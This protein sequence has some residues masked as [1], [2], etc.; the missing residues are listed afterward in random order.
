MGA[1]LRSSTVSGHRARQGRPPGHRRHRCAA[2]RAI[3]APR[4]AAVPMAPPGT[5]VAM[6]KTTPFTIG[7]DAK[8]TDGACGKVTCVVVDPV[9]R[10][11]T[12]LVVEKH[13]YD[14]RV[15]DS[16]RDRPVQG[17]ARLGAVDDDDLYRTAPLD[18]YFLA[19]RV[20]TSSALRPAAS[21]VWAGW[22]AY[23]SPSW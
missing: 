9:A 23:G 5:R 11:V 21:P 17:V 2:E 16:G 3:P 15:P 6:A 8:C 12:H 10:A 22:R 4:S 14:L 18:L 19:H 7:A 1:G 20:C 13:R